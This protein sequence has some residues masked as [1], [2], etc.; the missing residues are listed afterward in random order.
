MVHFAGQK[1]GGNSLGQAMQMWQQLSK[2][3]VA[4]K[5]TSQAAAKPSANSTVTP[6]NPATSPSNNPDASAGGT[7]A[8]PPSFYHAPDGS[9]WV[10]NGEFGVPQKL[11][12]ADG[13]LSGI[14]PVGPEA[15]PAST[16][17]AQAAN[18]FGLNSF[19]GGQ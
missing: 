13:S 15:P 2:T 16:S 6:P 9:L 19:C 5:A 10:Q 4:S 14:A 1:Q 17:D 7:L 8:T 12:E 11:R 3:L 18:L